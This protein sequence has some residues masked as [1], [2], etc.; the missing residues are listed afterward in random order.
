MQA[1]LGLE[2]LNIIQVNFAMRKFI[3]YKLKFEGLKRLSHVWLVL[4][5]LIPVPLVDLPEGDAQAL[6]QLL[7]LFLGPVWIF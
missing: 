1:Q 3:I 7:H 4:V 6:G 2:S 5:F